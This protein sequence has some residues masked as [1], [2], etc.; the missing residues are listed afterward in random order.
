MEGGSAVMDSAVSRD[1]EAP[2][3][4]TQLPNHAPRKHTRDVHILSCGFLLIFLAYGAAQNLESSVNTTG[5][6]GTISLGI[7]Y[8]SFTIFSLGASLV[9]RAL[10]SKNAVLLGTSGYWLFIAANLRPSWYTMI[11]ASLYLGFAASI[12]WVGEGTYLTSTAWSHAKDSNLHEGTVIGSFNGE[13]WGFF[14]S[15]QFVGNLISL[16]VL[17]DDGSGTTGGTNLLFTVFLCSM[18]LGTILLCFLRK[19]DDKEGTSSEDPSVSLYSYLKCQTNLVIS[20]LF[21]IRMLLIIP[22]I[23]YSGLQQ[24]FVW[25]EFTKEVVKPALG[26]RGVGG[27]MAVYGAFDAICSLAAGRLTSGLTSITWIVSG[28][29]VLQGCVFLA[30]LVRH[31]YSGVYTYVFPLLLASLLGIGDGV[32]NTQLN[33]LIALLFKQNTEAAFAQLKVWQSGAIAA[34]F[35]LSPYITLQAMLVTML[36]AVF[37]SFFAFLFLTVHLEKAFSHSALDV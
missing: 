30:L 27:S 25:A 36:A 37:V 26:V 7:L 22:L 10:G 23:A 11:P 34:V 29:A 21:D 3:V 5:N 2:L 6:L 33:A 17:Q 16:T 35:F 19:R 4:A 8:V 12:I 15:H 1:E 24:A 14:A 32:L 31:S 9:V 28:G 20:P 13:F 18:T